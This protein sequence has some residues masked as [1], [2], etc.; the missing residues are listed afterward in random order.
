MRDYIIVI[1]LSGCF[2]LLYVIIAVGYKLYSRNLITKAEREMEERKKA[3]HAA[4][5]EFWHQC[6]DQEAYLDE[7][8]GQTEVRVSSPVSTH[9]RTLPRPHTHRRQVA[10]YP[11]TTSTIGRRF[12]RGH[13]TGRSS[14]LRGGESRESQSKSKSSIIMGRESE[15]TDG[16]HDYPR[17][18]RG[19][20]CE[21]R[22]KKDRESRSGN[23]HRSCDVMCA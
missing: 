17:S 2:L 18:V 16:K 3:E 14:R 20:E 4:E 23:R 5:I 11:A 15:S 7:H 6:R 13:S 19:R 8:P 1:T 21:P 12:K 10:P 9:K 22:G